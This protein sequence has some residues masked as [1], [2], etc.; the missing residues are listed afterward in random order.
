[1]TWNFNNAAGLRFNHYNS[2]VFGNGRYLTTSNSTSV[3]RTYVAVGG[4]GQAATSPDAI[5]WTLRD[6]KAP[7][8]LFDVTFANGLFVAVGQTGDILTSP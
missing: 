8:I 1:M 5:N 4:N 7:Q 3:M 6:S 2:L